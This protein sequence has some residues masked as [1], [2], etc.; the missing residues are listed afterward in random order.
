MQ[1]RVCTYEDDLYYPFYVNHR[2]IELRGRDIK[3]YARNEPAVLTKQ[4]FD[5]ILLRLSQLEEMIKK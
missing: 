2:F 4:Q 5:D 3:A 1:V